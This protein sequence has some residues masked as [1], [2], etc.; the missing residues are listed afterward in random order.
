MK[1]VK[2]KILFLFCFLL[3]GCTKTNKMI[4]LSN[5]SID[6]IKEYAIKNE[7]NLEID[8]EF[9]DIEKDKIISQS[10]EVDSNI[11]K[12]DNLKIIISKGI[13]YDTLYKENKVNELGNIPIMMYHGIVNKLDED[14]PYTGG[15]VDKDGYHRTTESFIKD[16]EFYYSEGYRM[17]RLEDYVK[18]VIDVPLGKSPIVLT[19][20]DGLENSIKV[21]GVDDNGIIIDPNCAVGILES[22][23]KK[24][25]D[26]NVTATFF[27]N[28]TLFRQP[29]Y[30]EQIL[31][32]LV[33]NG[34]DIGNHSYNHA[35]FTKISESKSEEEIGKLYNLLDKY[36]K[37][38]YINIVALP[39]G[40]PYKKSHNNFKHI[41][42]S[43]YENVVYNTI[44]TLQVGWEANYSPFSSNFD[45]S[46]IKRI[47]AYD[48][49]GTNF[50]I[51]HN[52][53]RLKNN[54]YISDGDKNKIVV[55]AG[56]EVNNKFNLEVIYY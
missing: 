15:N 29:K 1:N 18:G 27:V 44:S 6:E 32:W 16:L 25:P 45:E 35:D 14:T 8:Y 26:Y 19:F 4:D 38:K 48:N 37:D 20:D 17:I 50:D 36:I 41:I 23:K 24:Y 13:D 11:N 52:F 55:P 46:F 40:S 10:I 7:L 31:N 12:N 33:D 34:Y 56:S 39:F 42:N 43:S 28:G 21:T 9:S 5:K 47:R 3:I 51:T 54:K 53:N 30:N 22:F 2:S 49:N